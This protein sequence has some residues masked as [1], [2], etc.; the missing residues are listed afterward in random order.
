M[1]GGL[2]L[3]DF[4]DRAADLVARAE[5]HHVLRDRAV[6][7]NVSDCRHTA[8]V[9]ESGRDDLHVPS[10]VAIAVE[11][12]NISV[13]AETTRTGT[14]A[15]CRRADPLPRSAHAH[16]TQAARPLQAAC[17]IRR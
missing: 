13:S 14:V 7:W 3:M 10:P 6:R 17:Q 8:D 11:P 15:R 1:R 2:A 5:L 9:N 16:A 12:R 4:L